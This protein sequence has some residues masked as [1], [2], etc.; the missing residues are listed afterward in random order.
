VKSAAIAAFAAAGILLILSLL[1]YAHLR[2]VPAEAELM[3]KLTGAVPHT[4]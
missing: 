1:G 4:A 3:P 2:R